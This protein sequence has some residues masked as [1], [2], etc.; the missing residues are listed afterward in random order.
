MPQQELEIPLF[1]H[2]FRNEKLG[3]YVN[4]VSSSRPSCLCMPLWLANGGLYVTKPGA[5][6]KLK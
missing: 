5:C 1:H 6:S 3:D 2:T 4:E